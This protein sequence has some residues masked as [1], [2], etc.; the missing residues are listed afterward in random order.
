LSFSIEK[1][2]K[3]YMNIKYFASALM[4]G[5]IIVMISSCKN[6]KSTTVNHAKMYHQFEKLNIKQIQPKGWIKEFLIRQKKGLTGNIEV[7]GYPFNTCLWACE[8]MKGSAKAWWPYEQTAYYLDGVHRLGLLLND[9]ELIQ[10]ARKNTKYVLN[11]IDSTGRFST[12]LADRWWRWPY[13]SFNRIFMTQ[14]EETKDP[15]IINALDNHYLTFKAEDFQDDLE[16]ANVEQ[17]CWLYAITANKKFMYM[18]EKAY[19]LFKSDITNRNRGNSDIQFASDRIPNHHGV[20]YQELAKV[21]ALLY[22]HTGKQEYLVEAENALN[23]MEK[24]HM[25]VNGLPSATEHFCGI[26]ETA[27]VEICNTAVMPYTYGQLLRINGDA[28]LA[29]KIEKAIFNGAI[30]SILKDFKA[31]Q[32]FSAP[33]QVIAT[34][35]SNPF[36]HHP[37]RLAFLPGHDVECC[38]G[39]VNRFMP[40]YVEQMWLKSNDH[41]IVAS[42]YG[43]SS[44][45]HNVGND[46][47]EVEIDQ[48]TDYPFS[49]K[50]QFIIKTSNDVNFP[51]YIRIPNW[52]DHPTI[53][54][55]EKEVE[56]QIQK[57][58]FFCLH[59]SFRDGDVIRLTLP[60]QI[61][62]VNATPKGISIERGPL[63]FSL[64]IEEEGKI[65]DNYEK[66]TAEFPG[67][68]FTPISVWNYAIA[69]GN[70]EV[71]ENRLQ[72][73]P[74][75]NDAAPIKL[76]APA[77]KVKNWKL[78]Q[79]VDKRFKIKSFRTPKFPDKPKLSERIET[80]ELVPYGN[81]MLRITVFPKL[82]S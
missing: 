35:T 66:S 28:T 2:V 12:K 19:K 58:R 26:S 49:D 69:D 46:D 75:D 3:K 80:I 44:I 54:V 9:D 62:K 13:V 41:G 50:I 64:P 55:N 36:G 53:C 24:Y 61:R 82:K 10:K 72:G 77:V 29:D 67:W 7:A 73:Y 20:V 23:K 18:A 71:K 27:G 40:Y 76:I 39:N 22:K 17:L 79:V 48:I 11:H 57:G 38:T 47:E 63:V 52:C 65:F 8:K 25:L 1:A 78:S 74:W 42:L 43:A 5:I 31:H 4:A 70:I 68:E 30:G 51:F 15:Q 33:N 34:T 56:G 32:Y 37:A 60:M 16:L 59:R 45:K 14:Y 21:P 81:T 6:Y